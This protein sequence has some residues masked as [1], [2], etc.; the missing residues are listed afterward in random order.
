MGYLIKRSNKVQFK[1]LPALDKALRCYLNNSKITEVF[2]GGEWHGKRC[3]IIGGGES[4]VGFD[5]SKLDNELTIGINK[6]FQFYPKVKIDYLMDILFYNKILEDKELL[7]K[8]KEFKGIKVFLSP[9][10]VKNLEKDVFLIKRL[11]DFEISLDLEKGIYGGNNSG[12]GALMLA[13]ALGA[14]PIYLLG[15][16]FKCDSQSHWH[17]G[18]GDN[19]DLVKY[20]VRLERFMPDFEKLSTKIGNDPL[21]IN[22]SLVSKLNCFLF[23]NVNEILN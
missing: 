13:I 10:N 17:G 9:S 7:E 2:R 21:I 4:L 19:R 1:R 14:D 22:L 18:Y 3:F 20:R 8:W 16:D 11:K 15:Y 12:F 23:N 5:F 6:V